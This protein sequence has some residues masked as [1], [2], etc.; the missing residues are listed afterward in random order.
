MAKKPK[1]FHPPPLEAVVVL[2]LTWWRQST[3]ASVQLCLACVDGVTGCDAVKQCCAVCTLCVT[4]EAGR[5]CA[6]VCV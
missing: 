2:R 5:V 4:A 6:C 3:C 1:V